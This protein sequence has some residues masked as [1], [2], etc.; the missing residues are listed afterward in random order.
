M[1]YR[2]IKRHQTR[3]FIQLSA[4]IYRKVK[5]KGLLK[6]SRLKNWEQ[7]VEV[8]CRM[9]K[10]ILSYSLMFSTILSCSVLFFTYS[11]YSVKSEL[12]LVLL[13]LA[14]ACLLVVTHI[15]RK[16][17][18]WGKKM[19]MK[20]SKKKNKRERMEWKKSCRDFCDYNFELQEATRLN[21]SL[22]F[23]FHLF[24]LSLLFILIFIKS[25]FVCFSSLT[26][27]SSYCYFMTITLEEAAEK[28]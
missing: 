10:K 20:N 2:D 5:V 11:F 24:C 3:R 16:H 22:Y 25:T 8:S 28:Q 23:S 19:S 7:K 18:S 17:H 6:W 26:F 15:D 4:Q 12:I 13:V 21:I 1:I 27:S 9:L 14:C